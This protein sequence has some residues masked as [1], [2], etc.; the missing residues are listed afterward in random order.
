MFLCVRVHHEAVRRSNGV[1]VPDVMA[2]LVA[3][4]RAGSTPC[5]NAGAL[6]HWRAM[7]NPSDPSFTPDPST[8]IAD[9]PHA[10]VLEAVPPPPTPAT[11][12]IARYGCATYVTAVYGEDPRTS[13]PA[14]RAT[15]LPST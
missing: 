4:C 12:P 13:A 15:S 6:A 5:A 10:P 1:D 3:E 14:E 8:P 7:A 9:D 11:L 2:R